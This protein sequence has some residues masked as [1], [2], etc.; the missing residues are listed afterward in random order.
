MMEGERPVRPVSSEEEL[1]RCLFGRNADRGWGP[2]YPER[3]LETELLD[4]VKREGAWVD[5]DGLSWGWSPMCAGN[6]GGGTFVVVAS[7]YDGQGYHT[8]KVWRP[9]TRTYETQYR[10]I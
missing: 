2:D 3:Y 10:Y 4:R 8:L 9:E 5:G 7:R 1:A 6:D